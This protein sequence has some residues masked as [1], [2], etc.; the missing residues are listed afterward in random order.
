MAAGG[1]VGPVVFIATWSILGTGRSGYAPV[2]DP[3]SELA[4]I[5][6]TSR[7]AMTTGFVVFAVGVGTYAWAL[8]AALPGGAGLAMAASAVASLGVAAFPL[9]AGV[10]DGPHAAAA[11]A[12]Y[13]ALT[14]APLLGART[15]QRRGRRGLAVGS[16]VAGVVVGVALLTAVVTSSSTGLAQRIGLTAADV[17]IMTTAAMILG[18][19]DRPFRA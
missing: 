7:A 5:G 17:W 18:A 8:A 15:L 1:V 13:L 6:A 14:A 11:G 10:G 12:A 9:G 2:H 4:E 16:V 19:G 3:I